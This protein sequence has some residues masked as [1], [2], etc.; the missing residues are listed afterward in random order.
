LVGERG[1]R[2][3]IAATGRNDFEPLHLGNGFGVHGPE[4]AC[5]DNSDTRHD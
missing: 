3:L 2:R 1:Q 4:M 5:P